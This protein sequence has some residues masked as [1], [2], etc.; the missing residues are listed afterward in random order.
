MEAAY[1]LTEFNFARSLVAPIPI[2]D[3]LERHLKLTLDFDDLHSRLGVPRLGREPEVLGAL[4]AESREVF[5]DQSLDPVENPEMEGRY[6]FTLAHEI[7]HW[8]LHR[9][10]LEQRSQGRQVGQRPTVICRAT[11]AKERVEWQA[12]YFASCL[13]MPRALL[14]HWWREEFSRSTPLIFTSFQSSDWAKPPMGWT[15]SVTLPTHLRGQVDPRAVSYFFYRA[16]A[17]IAPIFNV[18]MQAAQNRLQDV[19]LLDI[20][21]PRQ[22]SI[23][24]TS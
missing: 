8:Q 23:L 1:L 13:L 19:G 6:R 24:S 12:D 22:Q 18:S 14:H 4:W 3:L 5:I 16:S 20:E 7:G 10:Y 17:R 9:E 15:A 21:Y 2:E 11:Q